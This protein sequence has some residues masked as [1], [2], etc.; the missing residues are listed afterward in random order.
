M[1]VQ[2]VGRWL[3]RLAR[4]DTGVL[5]E[6]GAA[7]LATGPLLGLAVGASLA[8]G[9]GPWLWWLN[10]DLPSSGEAFFKAVVVGGLL[11]V[12]AWAGWLYVAYVLATTL[13]GGS[14][15]LMAV[16]RAM[17]LAFTP[18]ALAV[19]MFIE[20][21]AVGL[22]V[23]ALGAT[24]AL[25]QAALQA[26]T[27]LEP[28]RALVANLAGFVLFALV[29]TILGSVGDIEVGPFNMLGGLA[30]GIFFFSLD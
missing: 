25:S 21:L 24:L 5:A 16:F 10:Q 12:A 29:M 9:V 8:S 20:P 18:M 22:G 2:T 17:A 23:V 14:G 4:L 11:Q 13:L 28:G 3:V 30:P 1:N 6:A 26:T 7:T 27:G 15:E 19:L